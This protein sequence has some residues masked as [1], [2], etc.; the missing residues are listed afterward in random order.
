M[1]RKRMPDERQSI[2]HKFRIRGTD[3]EG[4]P[5]DYKGYLTVGFFEDGEVGE[6]FIKMDKQGS[7]TSGFV[8]AWAISVSMLL[9]TGTSLEELCGKFRNIA[10]EPAG[11]TDNPNIRFAR[12]PIDYI[13]RYLGYK[14]VEPVAL[15]EVPEAEEGSEVEEKKCSGCGTTEGFI[16]MHYGSPMCG[17]CRSGKVMPESKL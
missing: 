6:I 16:A 1:T 14:F 17:S 12:S 3:D 5:T 7:K 2:T 15:V 10:F 9:Q 8:D 4:N 11:Q 13:A